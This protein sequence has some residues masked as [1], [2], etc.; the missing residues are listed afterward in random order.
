MSSPQ[1]SALAG[2]FKMP[3]LGES[4][5]TGTVTRWLKAVGD[6]V[7]FDDPLLEVATDKV[8]SEIPSPYAGVLLEIMVPEGE[9]VE[10]GAPLARIGA[11]AT[12]TG[13]A[14]GSAPA[15]G[16]APGTRSAPA[17]APAG[18]GAGRALV[19]PIVRQR[20]PGTASTSPPFRDR[21]SPGGSCARTS[22]PPSPGPA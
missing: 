8:D 3:K 1:E 10:V 5:T 16:S 6:P 13:S 21:A 14:T 9:T 7:G 11:P 12:A 15:P 22:R 20:P 17:D 18:N 19:S 2:V 4:V